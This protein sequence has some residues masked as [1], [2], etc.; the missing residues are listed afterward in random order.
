MARCFDMGGTGPVT[1]PYTSVS[2]E[3][4]TGE[5]LPKNSDGS[6]VTSE[7]L[8]NSG[9]YLKVKKLGIAK[10]L[11]E[12][13]FPGGEQEMLDRIEITGFE[14]VQ[15]AEGGTEVITKFKINKIP[16]SS[17]TSSSSSGSQSSTVILN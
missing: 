8:M 1:P 14:I 17:S 11:G 10:A 13:Y 4:K 16:T 9:V 2:S 6:S 7:Q 3:Y 15:T 12:S 5:N